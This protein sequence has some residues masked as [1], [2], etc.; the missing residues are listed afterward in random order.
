MYIIKRRA[1]YPWLVHLNVRNVSIACVVI[2]RIY[3]MHLSTSISFMCWR[4]Q[5][6]VVV[7]VEIVVGEVV[8][9]VGVVVEG[10]SS[11]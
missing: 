2:G 3:E 4:R 7:V 11:P 1:S 10:N 6:L 5:V 9:E 8:V